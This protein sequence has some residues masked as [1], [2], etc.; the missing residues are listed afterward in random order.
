MQAIDEDGAVGAL[1]EPRFQEGIDAIAMFDGSA[2]TDEYLS[3][4]DWRDA[5]ELA[6]AASD[7]SQ[8]VANHLNEQF[9]QDFVFKIRGTH[10]SGDRDT[11]P[12]SLDEWSGG[13]LP[14]S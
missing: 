13:V 2:G 8:Q 12:G 11:T 3:A 4:W 7:V 6:G 14:A 10:Q 9:P 1:L 5:G